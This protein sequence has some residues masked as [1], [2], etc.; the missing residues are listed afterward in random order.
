[1]AS[2]SEAEN[3]PLRSDFLRH[4]NKVQKYPTRPVQAK[5]STVFRKY[6]KAVWMTHLSSLFC[7]KQIFRFVANYNKVS[8]YI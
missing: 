2:S 1:M 6:Y 4:E 5:I 8:E 3:K 7:R